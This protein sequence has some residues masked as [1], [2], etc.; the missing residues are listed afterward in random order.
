MCI[1]K[2]MTIRVSIDQFVIKVPKFI[3]MIVTIYRVLAYQ[4]PIVNPR[5]LLKI[6]DGRKK[7]TLIIELMKP[8]IKNQSWPCVNQDPS[9]ANKK[10]NYQ[11]PSTH[12]RVH[13]E[14][15]HTQIILFI[16]IDSVNELLFIWYLMLFWANENA[17]LIFSSF[18][19][20]QYICVRP[21]V[22][23]E[24][25][26]QK[27]MLKKER[28]NL[29]S[30]SLIISVTGGAKDFWLNPLLKKKCEQSL[31]SVAASTGKW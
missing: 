28:W 8:P 26:K 16:S 31:I 24:D 3:Q 27:L 21:D 30:P 11:N 23:I 19:I 25:L 22:N 18:Q 5:W 29:K 9:W 20:L 17:N 6:Q 4:V 1:M 2:H 7:L 10:K 12:S 14:R 13:S 15:T